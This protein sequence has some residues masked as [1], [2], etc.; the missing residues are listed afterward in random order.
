MG[1]LANVAVVEPHD[2]KP[3]RSQSLAERL[4]PEDELGA[5]AHDEQNKRVALAPEGF[6]FNVDSISSDVRHFGLLQFL[7]VSC[8]RKRASSKSSAAF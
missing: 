6:I 2:A 7:F 8:P 5:E 3:L 1:R 4:R